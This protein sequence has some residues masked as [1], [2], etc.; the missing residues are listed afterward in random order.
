M[1]QYV[2]GAVIKSLRERRSLTQ[3]QLA[4]RLGVGDKAVSRWETGSSPPVPPRSSPPSSAAPGSG[5]GCSG[6]RQTPPGCPEPACQWRPW[7]I[8]R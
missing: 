8:L 2:T 7:G 5:G 3:A 6:R 1:N 4:D